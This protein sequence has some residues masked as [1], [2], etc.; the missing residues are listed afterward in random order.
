MLH[1]RALGQREGILDIDAEIAD[2]ALNFRVAEQDLHGTQVSRLLV[3][4][5]RFRPAE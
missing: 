5:R 3:D 1:L 4:D 2:R